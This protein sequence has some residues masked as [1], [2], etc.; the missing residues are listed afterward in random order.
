M[1]PHHDSQE[2]ASTVSTGRW[3]AAARALETARPDRLFNDPWAELLAG[4]SGKVI[5]DTA[6]YNPFLPVRTRYFDDRIIDAARKDSQLVLLGAGL[7]TRAFRLPLSASCTVFEIDYSEAFTEKEEVLCAVPAACER[8]CIHADLSG[9]WTGALLEAGFDCHAPTIWVAEGLFF[10]LTAADVESLLRAAADLFAE[11][12]TFLADIFGTGLFALEGMA[13][14]VAA[15]KSTG[16]ALPFCTD[17]PEA[18][19][20]ATGWSNASVVQPGQ[21]TANFD[22]M[23]QAPGERDARQQPNLR[24][25]LVTATL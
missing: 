13:P 11:G 7:D 25:Y 4:E 21:P 12:S 18:L 14:L 19:F 10:Y 15:R 8:K 6:D 1:T 3:I 23:S 17:T 16:R 9:P 5:L 20:R 24:T 2:R 22:R